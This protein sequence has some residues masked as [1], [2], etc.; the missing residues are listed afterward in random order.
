CLL[1]SNALDMAQVLIDVLTPFRVFTHKLEHRNKPTL[2][3]LPRAVD[4]LIEALQPQSYTDTW[5]TMP[6]EIVAQANKIL[7]ILC[8]S[9]K[10]RFD[11]VFQSDSLALAAALLVPG[12]K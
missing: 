7:D 2:C 3:Y 12:P 6:T 1:T 8:A 10:T 11:W 9:V 4:D 5:K